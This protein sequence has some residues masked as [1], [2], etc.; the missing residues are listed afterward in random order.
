MHVLLTQTCWSSAPAPS[1]QSRQTRLIQHGKYSSTA[2]IQPLYTLICFCPQQVR[3]SWLKS[4]VH[5]TSLSTYSILAIPS[6]HIHDAYFGCSSGITASETSLKLVL[7]LGK[8]E[9]KIF[10]SQKTPGIPNPHKNWHPGCDS[11]LN[12]AL[13]KKVWLCKTR[14]YLTKI[15]DEKQYSEIFTYKL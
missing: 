13:L 10:Q 9:K 6:L 15:T 1:P 14:H 12:W 7:L 5:M 2:M 8:L 4:I 3:K 11:S